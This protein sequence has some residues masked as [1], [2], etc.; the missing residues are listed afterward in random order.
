VAEDLS[1]EGLSCRVLPPSTLGAVELAEAYEGMSESLDRGCAVVRAAEAPVT[2]SAPPGR[3][4]RAGHIAALVGLWLREGHAFLAGASDGV[5][6]SS[7]AAGAAVDASFRHLGVERIREA[8]EAFDTA[9]L[10]ED[11]G[12]AIHLG[13]TGKN[14]ADVHVLC[15]LR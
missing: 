6:G 9:R 13:P 1:E 14:F 10:H 4:G 3:G 8:L 7:G 12:T 2:V 11:A 5:D 15:R